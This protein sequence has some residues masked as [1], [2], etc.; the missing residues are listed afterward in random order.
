MNSLQPLIESIVAE[1][2]NVEHGAKL[3]AKYGPKPKFTLDGAYCGI[4]DIKQ[5][6]FGVLQKRSGKTI[7]LEL[8]EEYNSRGVIVA[9]DYRYSGQIKNFRA[10]GYGELVDNKGIR[11]RGEFKA[12]K[13]VGYVSILW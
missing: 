7:Y 9:D 2:N 10:H 12:G 4:N 5:P 13:Q 1:A 8:D 11:K 6:G 3:Y